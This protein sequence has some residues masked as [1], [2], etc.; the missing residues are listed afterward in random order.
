M[1]GPLPGAGG[2]RRGDYFLTDPHLA[3]PSAPGGHEAEPG[4]RKPAPCHG[5][6]F[7]ENKSLVLIDSFELTDG[8]FAF[9]RSGNLRIGARRIGGCQIGC[10]HDTKESVK[11]LL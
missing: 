5:I 9:S 1:K 4:A 6:H 7:F 10:C 11:A 3:A 8:A 2:S